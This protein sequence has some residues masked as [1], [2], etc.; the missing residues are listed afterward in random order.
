MITTMTTTTA[1]AT[2]AAI[3]NVGLSRNS[4]LLSSLPVDPLLLAPA[5]SIKFN[6]YILQT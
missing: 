4:L 1:P 6:I 5:P 3:T 2:P